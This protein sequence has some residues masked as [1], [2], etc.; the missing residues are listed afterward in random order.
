MAV[1][2]TL[3]VEHG[4]FSTR[5][6]AM[7]DMI[8]TGYWPTTYVSHASPELPL[9]WHQADVMGYVVEGETYVLDER[10]DRQPMRKGDRLTLPA[11]ALH[12]EG[13]VTDQVIY[14]VALKVPEN[15]A[16]AF[17]LYDPAAYPE[18]RLLELDPSLFR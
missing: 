18:P 12:G 15:F 14:L 5:D 3:Q 7:R 4:Y 10:G 11:G 6:E 13:E 17:R 1:Q 2:P 8:E 9:H 16:D